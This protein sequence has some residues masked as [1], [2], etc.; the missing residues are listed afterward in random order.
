MSNLRWTAST[1]EVLCGAG[2]AKTV[3]MISAPSSNQRLIALGWG[4][5]FDSTSV[6]AQPA[7]VDLFYPPVD[8]AGVFTALVLNK[9]DPSQPE[10][11]Q[12]SGGFNASTEPMSGPILKSVQ[13]HP[14]AGYEYGWPMGREMEIAGGRRLAIRV[15]APDTINAKAWLWIDE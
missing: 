7:Q 1:T 15:T 13:V 2:V 12:S 8:S 9:C 4:I 11:I 10:T 14:Q 6:Q 5:Y 3:L